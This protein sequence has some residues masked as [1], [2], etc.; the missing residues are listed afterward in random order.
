M[1]SEVPRTLLNGSPAL[2][3]SGLTEALT[4]PSGLTVARDR[5]L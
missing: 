4:E 2:I 1:A 5:S 3:C